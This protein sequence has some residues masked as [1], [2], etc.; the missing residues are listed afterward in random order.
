MWRGDGHE[1]FFHAAD[2]KLMAV[3]VEAGTTLTTGSPAALFEFRAGG[4]LLTPYYF[5]TADGQ[6]FPVC[7]IVETAGATPLTLLVDWIDAQTSSR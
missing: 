7:S 1:L 3:P 4:G 2:G 6:R 5:P